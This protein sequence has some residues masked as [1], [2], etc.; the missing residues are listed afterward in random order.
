MRSEMLQ[1]IFRL[2]DNIFKSGLQ[3]KS[4][5]IFSIYKNGRNGFIHSK[6]I[7]LKKGNQ[8][9]LTKTNLILIYNQIKDNKSPNQANRLS[10]CQSTILIM[11]AKSERA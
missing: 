7:S 10:N 1:K 6:L 9:W 11:N 5:F 2:H 3:I 4:M 8:I